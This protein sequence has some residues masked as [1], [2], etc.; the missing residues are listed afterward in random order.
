MRVVSIYVVKL[1]NYDRVWSMD[2]WISKLSRK[3]INIRADNDWIN[4]FDKKKAMCVHIQGK[5]QSYKFYNKLAESKVD[6]KP[7]SI[8]RFFS[9]S[10]FYIHN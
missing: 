6:E 7:T 9:D 8:M 10:T 5:N 3:K 4:W 1:A 2:V